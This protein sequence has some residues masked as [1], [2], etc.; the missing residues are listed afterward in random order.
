VREEFLAPRHLAQ[1]VALIEWVT[2]GRA[3]ETRG[4]PPSKP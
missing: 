1:Y 3:G 2:A 4:F